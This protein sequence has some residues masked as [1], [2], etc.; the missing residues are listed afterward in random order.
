MITTVIIQNFV[1]RGIIY[2]RRLADDQPGEDVS[3]S[4][5]PAAIRRTITRQMADKFQIIASWESYPDWPYVNFT[6]SCGD[7]DRSYSRKVY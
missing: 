7:I 4:E 3:D 5:I 1:E 6:Y 2:R